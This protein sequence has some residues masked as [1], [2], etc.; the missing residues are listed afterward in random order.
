[1]AFAGQ[2]FGFRWVWLGCWVA[3]AKPLRPHPYGWTD[4]ILL[5]NPRKPQACKLQ[6]KAQQ[7]ARSHAFNTFLY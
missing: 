5:L 3:G 6:V 7:Q 2:S 1:M 4:Y